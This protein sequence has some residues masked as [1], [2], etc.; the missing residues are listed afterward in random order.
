VEAFDVNDPELSTQAWSDLRRRPHFYQTVWFALL[1]LAL[2]GG[3]AWSLHWRKTRRMQEK[4][5]AVI[6][7]RSRVAGEIHDT[8]I[9]G[10]TSVSSLLEA[11]R[12]LEDQGVEHDNKLLHAASLQVR[13]TIDEARQA[14]WGLRS[15]A[16]AVKDIAADLTEIAK[17]V[18]REFQLPIRCK[19]K[20][21]SMPVGRNVA[22]E[23]MMVTRE[24]LYNAARHGN[25]QSV[26]LLVQFDASALEISIRD[27]GAGFE[28]SQAAGAGDRH[29][30]LAVMQERIE[31][32][33]G[34]FTIETSAG[35]G[36]RLTITMKK[37]RLFVS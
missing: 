11:H 5:D 36:A 20:G 13:S 14:I 23:L 27:D 9:Q 6:G 24:A 22:H 19:I 21:R 31:R 26:E 32:L 25:P 35:Q 37:A 18:D 29:Y 7:E 8:L 15:G 33:G 2:C 1:C 16:V 28:V 34:K 12:S 30:G 3:A 4:F 17:Q 10:C